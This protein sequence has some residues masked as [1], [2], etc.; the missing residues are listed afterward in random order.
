MRR[1]LIAEGIVL[2]VAILFS[3]I[4]FFVPQDI[5]WHPLF[6]GAIFLL[7]GGLGIFFSRTL[8]VLS[9]VK[10]QAFLLILTIVVFIIALLFSN[11]VKRDLADI[12]KTAQYT[13]QLK[14][15]K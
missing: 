5:V 2:L 11:K 7:F 6:M 4:Y 1:F 9:S 15:N 10:Y 12:A 8:S 3:L 13:E 14:V